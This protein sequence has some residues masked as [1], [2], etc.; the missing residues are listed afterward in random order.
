[1]RI[2]PSRTLGLL[3]FGLAT[4]L[5][6]GALVAAGLNDAAHAA[7]TP[8]GCGPSCSTNAVK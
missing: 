7:A 5:A 1:M 6:T 4:L 3:A 8:A 2:E